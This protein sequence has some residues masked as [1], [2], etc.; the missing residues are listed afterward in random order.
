MM[1]SNNYYRDIY[2]EYMV[3]QQ[4]RASLNYSYQFKNKSLEPLKK[5]K[6]AQADQPSSKYLQFL[7]E[8]NINPI[9]ARFSFRTDV[10]R[11]Y[12]E[13]QYRDLSQYY[14]GA[15]TFN[16][17]YFSNNFLFSWQYNLGF[18]LTRSLRLDLNASTTTLNDGDY[19]YK[20]D[21]SLIWENL[22]KVGRPINYD[23]RLQVNYKL[24]LKF[25]PYLSFM[26]ME[27][28]YGANYNWQ[29][30]SLA[31][32]TYKEYDDDGNVT[33]VQNLGDGVAQNS[34]SI[35]MIGD[36]DFTRFYTEFKGYKRY[37]S[38]LKGRRSELD[39]LNNA[40]STLALK[41][42]KRNSKNKYKFKN[43]F[44]AKDIGWMVLS[45]L[46]RVNF[47]YGQTNGAVIPGL[48][49]EPG[50]FGTNSQGAPTLGF[51][52]GSQFDIKRQLIEKG[53]VSDSDL[54][55]DP[56]QIT[57]GTNFNATALI[58][59]IPNLRIDLN[60]IHFTQ[61]QRFR[62]HSGSISRSWRSRSCKK[63]CRNN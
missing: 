25:F 29:A 27:L 18:D 17:P 56:Y 7:K 60:A 8:F 13:R 16:T 41:K 35:S 50:F 36:M 63:T 2:T 19:F 47:N 4:L 9:P 62:K 57:K 42:N 21:Q 53:L 32:R 12:S 3:D 49:T 28:A 58:E 30:Y 51:I 15:S 31:T 38:I 34:N 22:F 40:Y 20:A 33:K 59:P 23:Q 55:T 5:W 39:S 45:S 52:Y 44:Q 46:K 11:S 6:A 26:N 1:Y 48:F 61:L 24:P 14:G 54:M 37:D 43:K 10:A